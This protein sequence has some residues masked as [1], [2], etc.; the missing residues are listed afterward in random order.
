M[1]SLREITEDNFGECIKLKVAE[2]QKK[3]VA[4]NV[5]SIAQSKVYPYFIPLAVYNDEEMVGF[6]LHGKNPESKK[7]YIVR[8][9]IDEKFQGKGFGKLVTL[10]LIEKMGKNEDC[11]AIY[12][13][14]VEGNKGAEHLYRNIGFER[15]GVIDEDGEIEM[16]YTIEKTNNRQLAT[17]N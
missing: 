2:D 11:D 10:K 15:T 14:F 6:T 12:L 7:Y 17:N 5:M 1:I 3:F 13:S 4:T 16:K 8:L 9:M